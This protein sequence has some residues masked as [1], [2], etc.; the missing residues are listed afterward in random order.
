MGCSFTSIQFSITQRF[1]QL[2]QLGSKRNAYNV[3][4]QQK[5]HIQ[6]QEPTSLAL[7]QTSIAQ[8]MLYSYCFLVSNV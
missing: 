2:L 8:I 6:Q 3:S 1:K 4:I 5:A 7:R